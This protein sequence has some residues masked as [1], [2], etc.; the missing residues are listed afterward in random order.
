M[1]FGLSEE[2]TLLQTSVKR[3]LAEQYPLESVR[4]LRRRPMTT[5]PRCALAWPVLVS[6]HY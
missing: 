4:R 3:F 2:Q 6:P 1:E 5:A